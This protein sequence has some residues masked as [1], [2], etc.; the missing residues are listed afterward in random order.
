MELITTGFGRQSTARE[1]AAGIDL[2]GKQAIVTG[3][4]SGISIPTALTLAAN[5][6]EVTLAL[7]NEASAKKDK[8]CSLRLIFVDTS[9]AE[10]E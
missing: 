1:V 7:R 2:S 8:A 10:L 9:A 6:A 4:G 3:G 5:G